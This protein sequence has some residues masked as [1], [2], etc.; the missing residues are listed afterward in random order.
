M[1]PI[2]ITLWLTV[3]YNI[4]AATMLL[5]PTSALGQ[6]VEMPVGAPPIYLVACGYFVIL[7]GCAY[8][9]MAMQD[10]VV[11]PLL[12]FSALAKTGAFVLVWSLWGLGHV[13]MLFAILI[14]GDAIFATKWFRWLRANPEQNA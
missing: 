9:W 12:W 6:L 4:I 13:S 7:F 10:H 8:A 14:I 1:R 2:R 3:I 5:F 11:R